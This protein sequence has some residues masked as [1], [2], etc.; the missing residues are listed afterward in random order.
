LLSAG[1]DRQAFVWDTKSLYPSER[2]AVSRISENDES[3]YSDF[4]SDEVVKRQASM[5]VLAEG[6]DRFLLKLKEFVSKN[7]GL[8]PESLQ[9]LIRK[10]GDP[11]FAVRDN[12][13]QNLE[14]LGP[15]ISAA[16]QR[17]VRKE[18]DP[19]IRRRLQSIL[20]TIS[21]E[22]SISRDDVQLLRSVEVIERIGTARALELLRII[23]DRAARQR[24][25]DEAE[26]SIER[27]SERLSANQRHN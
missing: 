15:Q 7:G 9:P 21:S 4:F 12:A 10:L 3:V 16:L 26:L 1:A 19:E 22:T 17:G 13:Q 11:S 24:I 5:L 27:V 20:L 2:P 23:K 25:A 18:K 14:K 6:G 8:E